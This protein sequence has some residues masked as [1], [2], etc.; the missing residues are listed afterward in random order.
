[1][2]KFILSAIA[3]LTVTSTAIA[4][5]P[6]MQFFVNNE[7]AITRVFNTSYQPIACSGVTFGST[8]QGVVLNAYANNFVIA[9]GAFVD[10]YVSSNIYDPMVQAWA[11][12][13]CYAV[14][15]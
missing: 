14:W 8:Y 13:D 6:Q 11:Q 4:F 3:A 7:V 2:K 15:F 9:P 10:V 5:V 12:M 1:M